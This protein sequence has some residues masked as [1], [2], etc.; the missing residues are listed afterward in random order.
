V[1]LLVGEWGAFPSEPGVE[2]YQQQ[3]VGLF[4]RDGVSWARWSLDRTERLGLLDRSGGLT[5][6]AVQL[7][8][9]IAALPPAS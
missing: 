3:M 1:P 9:L 4:A 2:A 5:P 6:A 7:R 8:R